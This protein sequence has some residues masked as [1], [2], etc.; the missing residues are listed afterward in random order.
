M[1]LPVGTVLHGEAYDYVIESVLGHGTFGVT[2]KASVRLRG[3]LGSLRG[4]LYVAI[5]E[6]FLQGASTRDGS[7]L[8][9]GSQ[10]DLMDRC[11]SRFR[12]EAQLI[13]RLNHPGIVK[14]ME[15][16]EENDTAYYVMELIEGE[17]LSSRIQ[18]KGPLAEDECV[19]ITK[20][21]CDALDYMHSS[22]MLHLDLKPSNIMLRTDG[23][24]VLIDFGLS[25]VF[26]DETDDT[27]LS[28][29]NG[30]PGY[31]SIE[32]A[33]YSGPAGEYGQPV[34]MDVYSLGATM[35]NMLSGVRPPSASVV[36][37][38]GLDTAP[39]RCSSVLKSV[40]T[41]AMRPM[42]SERYPDMKALKADLPGEKKVLYQVFRIPDNAKVLRVDYLSAQ[43]P[44]GRLPGSFRV[45]VSRGRNTE[46]VFLTLIE[47]L[48]ALNIILREDSGRF[49]A[50][51]ID[52]PER[53]WLTYV[54]PD[55]RR[56]GISLDTHDFSCRSDFEID[57]IDDLVEKTRQIFQP[58][59]D[60][61]FYE[62]KRITTKVEKVEVHYE[63]LKNND[64]D[65]T[66]TAE[67]V[68][69]NGDSFA[70]NKEKYE[71]FLS[72]L[73]ENFNEKIIQN[74]E[75]PADRYPYDNKEMQ[76]TCDSQFTLKLY[77]EGKTHPTLLWV[78]GLQESHYGILNMS[79]QEAMKVFVGSISPLLYST[80]KY[81]KVGFAT[82]FLMLLLFTI[83][84]L[85]AIF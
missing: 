8:R 5:K 53:F 84:I 11:L 78:N 75:L 60:K 62:I 27:F 45:D 3:K 17:S 58:F 77:E 29:A 13:S 41:K 28:L 52:T 50:P 36:L 70:V 16:F 48:N 38:R 6:F 32:Q 22:D 4:N 21:L 15:E 20:E 39:L 18:S 57:N 69:I 47:K 2:Y 85:F 42:V 65:A 26:N 44:G 40:V 14:V 82:A 24:P 83:L 37:N 64:Y 31:A 30:T 72:L 9:Y 33:A 61:R 51:E 74:F 7:T 46:E 10:I 54:L 56:D 73:S 23:S 25:K 34:T 79:P 67:E 35:Y 12:K 76:G 71:H 43:A 63:G 1:F 59:I 49:K 55:G 81:D 80:S 19:R 68:I 66:F